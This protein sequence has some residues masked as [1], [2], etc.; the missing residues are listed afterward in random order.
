MSNQISNQALLLLYDFDD[1]LFRTSDLSPNGINVAKGYELAL[2]DIFGK[3]IGEGYLRCF[4]L[5]SK[6]PIEIVNHLLAV[7]NREDLLSRARLFHLS[8]PLR[9]YPIPEAGVYGIPWNEE[10]PEETITSLLVARKLHHLLGEVGKELKNT[11]WPAFCE[12]ATPQLL[13]LVEDL[14]TRGFPIEQGIVSSGHESFI[15]K[16][17]EEHGVS[18]TGI[19]VTDDDIRTRKYPTEI[20]RRVKPGQLPLALAHLAWLRRRRNNIP[21]IFSDN[22]LTEGKNSKSRILYFG[23]SHSKDGEMAKDAGVPFC[24][25][26]KGVF[27]RLAADL[28]ANLTRLDKPIFEIFPNLVIEGMVNPDILERSGLGHYARR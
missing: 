14:K 22:Y 1:T 6:A 5:E 16:T 13:T 3:G 17:L 23:D 21:P 10:N 28:A 2:D 26:K 19:L 11:K 20:E 18:F 7:S 25:Y 4:P 15:R 8:D 24:L 9:I 12:E 27:L